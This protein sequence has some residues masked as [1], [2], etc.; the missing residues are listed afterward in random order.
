MVIRGYKI[1]VTTLKV[2]TTQEQSYLSELMR[3]HT[4]PRHR[5]SS[6]CSRPQQ[7]Q[8]KLAFAEKVFC[9][10]APVVWN[11]LPQSTTSDFS[12]FTSFKR[13]LKTEYFNRAYRQ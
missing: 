8:V 1:A 13:L 11:S 2:L 6:G 9:H 10:A 5:R 7:H 12:C 3:L 4:L